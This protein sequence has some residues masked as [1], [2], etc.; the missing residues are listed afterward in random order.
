MPVTPQAKT[1]VSFAW[2][3]GNTSVKGGN[4]QHAWSS[5][6]GCVVSK[7]PLLIQT[8]TR[9]LYREATHALA[10][11]KT[12]YVA[13]TRHVYNLFPMLR[14]DRANKPH[15]DLQAPPHT[16]TKRPGGTEATLPQ[17]KDTLQGPMCLLH[18]ALATP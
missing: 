11:R 17:A 7:V 3:T 9:F 15:E 8:L 14:E 12:N 10:Q 4:G 6:V 13:T 2:G 16:L 5:A 18:W 1:N